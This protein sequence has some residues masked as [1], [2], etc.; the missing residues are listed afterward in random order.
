MLPLNVA[1]ELQRLIVCAVLLI[2]KHK[3]SLATA[4]HS[5]PADATN[6]AP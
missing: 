4:T 1:I 6:S 2:N 5:I 3:E